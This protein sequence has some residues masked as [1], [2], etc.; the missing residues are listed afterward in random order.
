MYSPSLSEWFRVLCSFLIIIF[1]P[2]LDA[3]TP[4][5]NENLIFFSR[6]FLMGILMCLSSLIFEKT[7]AVIQYHPGEDFPVTTK[8]LDTLHQLIRKDAGIHH[9]VYDLRDSALHFLPEKSFQIE[10]KAADYMMFYNVSLMKIIIL[11]SILI[12][13]KVKSRASISVFQ[14]G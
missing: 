4:M 7:I 9:L 8:F 14:R 13:W 2:R 11:L 1:Y 3:G 5:P 10:E 6:F 12:K